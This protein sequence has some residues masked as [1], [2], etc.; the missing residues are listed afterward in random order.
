MPQWFEKKEKLGYFLAL[1]PMADMTDQPFCR[2]CRE[3]SG[4]DFI[5]FREMVSSEA[6]VRGNKKTL[7]MCEFDEPE[8]LIV[9]QLFGAS[10]DTIV[11][12]AGIVVEKFQPNGI[13]INMGCP[14]PKITAKN[15]AGAA[16]MKNHD[17]AV[18]IIRKLKAA[19]FGVPISVKTRL[20]W[21]SDDEIL[22][23]APKLEEAGA[24]A[25]SIHGR[26]KTQGYNGRANWEKIAEVKKVLKIPV[27]AN[28]DIHSEADIQQCLEVT[29]ADGVMIGRGALG[30]PWIFSGR[31]PILEEIKKV[32]LRHAELHIEY[33]GMEHGLATFRKH[34]LWYFKG[35]KVRLIKNVKDLK[36]RLVKVNN[37]LDLQSLLSFFIG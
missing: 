13:D 34:L 7:R 21:G 27:I 36:T 15:L 35:E 4:K 2:I 23:F 25:I 26:T 37:L 11:R 18:E 31:V 33:Y 32:V 24:D 14:V 28:G 1:A 3:V 9:L 16:L 10:P 30:N 22:E 17:K 19:H 12:A 5:I 20:G 6:L 29:G 8:R